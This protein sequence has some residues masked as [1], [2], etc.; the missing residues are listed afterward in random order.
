[1]IISTRTR[2]NATLTASSGATIGSQAT[3]PSDRCGMDDHV[4]VMA[5]SDMSVAASFLASN[6]TVVTA[7][8]VQIASG[9]SSGID[10]HGMSLFADGNVQLTS[11]HRFYSCG[12]GGGS[13]LGADDLKYIKQVMPLNEAARIAAVN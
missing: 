3:L 9:T 11:Q 2:S 12:Y 7:G 13:V 6:V 4:F 1:M 8:D 5:R 10:F